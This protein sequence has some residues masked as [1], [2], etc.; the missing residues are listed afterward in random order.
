MHSCNSDSAEN[1]TYSM[2]MRVTFVS[3]AAVDEGGPRRE[4]FPTGFN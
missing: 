1:I 4:L 2:G 3:E